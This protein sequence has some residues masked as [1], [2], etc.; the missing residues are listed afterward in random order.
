M[1]QGNAMQEQ[2]HSYTAYTKAPPQ[3]MSRLNRILL[4]EVSAE[5]QAFSR[6][7]SRKEKAYGQTGRTREEKDK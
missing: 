6:A 4:F 2:T 3:A 1:G 7:K 5:R